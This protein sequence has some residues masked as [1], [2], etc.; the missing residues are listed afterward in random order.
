VL[1]PDEILQ[2]EMGLHLS[3][4]C[5]EPTFV[6]SEI[7]AKDLN[8]SEYQLALLNGDLEGG[9]ELLKLIL[10]KTRTMPVVIYGENDEKETIAEYL[11]T[12]ASDFMK[13][14]LQES[15]FMTLRSFVK[16]V[17][18]EIDPSDPVIEEAKVPEPV[19]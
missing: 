16:P 10:S 8:F 14:P 11:E 17:E 19:K 6:C 9:K 5:L 18:P 4:A 7:E 1:E 2:Q 3:K 13:L 12:G 15:D